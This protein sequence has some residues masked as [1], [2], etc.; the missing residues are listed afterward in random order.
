MAAESFSRQQSSAGDMK[1][2][3]NKEGYCSGLGSGS[4][5]MITTAFVGRA[6]IFK[7]VKRVLSFVVVLLA[8]HRRDLGRLSSSRLDEAIVNREVKRRGGTRATR[9]FFDMHRSPYQTDRKE[10]YKIEL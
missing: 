7:W 9:D 1:P 3:R 4:G 5:A 6:D 2:E 8:S 10:I